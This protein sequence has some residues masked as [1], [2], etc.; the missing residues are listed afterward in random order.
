MIRQ[1]VARAVAFTALMILPGFA[2]AGGPFGGFFETRGGAYYSP[3]HY[4]A[5]A[6]YRVQF[7]FHGP[8]CAA[9]RGNVYQPAAPAYSPPVATPIVT[10]AATNTVPGSLPQ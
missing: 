3:L 10:P 6:A 7:H 4:W 1:L 9:C 5:P 2:V 8:E